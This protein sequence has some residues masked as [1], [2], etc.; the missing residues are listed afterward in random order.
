MTYDRLT[1]ADYHLEIEIRNGSFTHRTIRL[2]PKL[3]ASWCRPL[4][5][6]G[7]D[8]S[9]SYDDAHHTYLAVGVA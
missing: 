4:H 3:F 6:Q 7:Y 1:K 9:I 5:E 2:A 8:M